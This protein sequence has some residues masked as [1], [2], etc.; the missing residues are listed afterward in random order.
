M[1][2]IIPLFLISIISYGC[3][4]QK[5]AFINGVNKIQIDYED[6]YAST[7]MTIKTENFYKYFGK[8]VKTVEIEKKEII[9]DISRNINIFLAKAQKVKQTPDVRLIVTFWKKDQKEI[10]SMGT[11]LVYYN[12][13]NYLA[14]DEIRNIFGKLT[15]NQW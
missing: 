4:I 9:F 3:K 13:K 1:K 8:S 15:N 14:N 11:T 7:P 6:L 2:K 10:L 5:N 12:K